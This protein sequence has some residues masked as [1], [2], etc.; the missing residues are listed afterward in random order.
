MTECICCS[1]ELTGRQEKYCS[2]KCSETY[3]RGVLIVGVGKIAKRFSARCYLLGLLK[4]AEEQ[5]YEYVTVRFN[6]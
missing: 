3:S 6:D 1:K 5:G 2:E 4:E